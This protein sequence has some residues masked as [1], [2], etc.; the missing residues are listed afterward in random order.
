MIDRL[1]LETSVYAEKKYAT[2]KRVGAGVEDEVDAE[3]STCDRRITMP[4]EP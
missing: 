4:P 2:M 1:D 3:A